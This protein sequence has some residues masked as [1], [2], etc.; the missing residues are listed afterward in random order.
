MG[1]EE[2][3]SRADEIVRR[4]GEEARACGSPVDLEDVRVRYL[5]RKGEL[6][7]L[8]RELGSLGP[9]E[10]PAAGNRLNRAKHAIEE[11][12]AEAAGRVGDGDR[13]TK[14][15][16][17]DLTLP[18]RRPVIGRL[19]PLT[20]T[21]EEILDV[22]RHL[23]FAVHEGP[24]VELERYNFDALNTP[25]WHPARDQH[26]SFFLAPGVV[27][28][29]HTSPVQV[30]VME[31]QGPPVRMVAPGRCFRRDNPDASHAIGFHQIEGLYVDRG[32]TFADL[33]GTLDAFARQ[34]LGETT[35]TRFRPSYFPFTEPSAEMDV[36]CL[37]CHGEGCRV[38]K[39]TG[40]LEVMGCGMVHPAVLAGVGHDPETYTGF[41]FGMG[42]D[43]ICMLRHGID[44]VRLLME[45][46]LR[47]LEQ[48]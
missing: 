27:L 15:P 28:R 48:F 30:R 21:T 34:L 45:N 47:F 38:C 29:T 8:L 6:T 33:R 23:G 4:A 20:Q 14:R 3:A 11:R 37:V 10:R 17:V 41:A 39:R 1:P 42:I 22:F 19:H 24:E 7:L 32:V 26:D 46:D 25:A 31:R 18:G 36:A 13:T 12:L 35:R 16:G 40:W 43:R 9:A 5:G 44:D 2:L